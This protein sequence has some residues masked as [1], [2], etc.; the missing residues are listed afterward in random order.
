MTN[1]TQRSFAGGEFAPAL[2]ARAD[3]ARFAIGLRTC[4][5]M[6]V[7]RAGGATKRPGTKFVDV[8]GSTDTWIL[9]DFTA[10]GTYDFVVTAAP[11]GAKVRVLLV[12]GGGA[13]AS[14][15]GT[16]VAGG[17]GG[18]GGVIEKKDADEIPVAVGSYPL[19]LGS[20]GGVTHADHTIGVGS[21][22]GNPGL[23]TTGF[24]LTAEGGGYGKANDAMPPGDG[25]CGGGMRSSAEDISFPL[26]TPVP[27]NGGNGTQGGDG[28]TGVADPTIGGT[29]NYGGGGGGAGELGG[30]YTTGDGGD[31]IASDITGTNAYYGGG[32]GA[33]RM[34]GANTGG[35]GG[36][37]GGGH[38][39]PPEVIGG[40]GRAGEDGKGGG[41]GGGGGTVFN[42]GSRG[43][44]G[45]IL[46]RYRAS[47][48]IVATGGLMTSFAA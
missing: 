5:N 8:V 22:S 32:G 43:G 42:D 33:G 11:A 20:G 44:D 23:E 27:S 4:R 48:G 39:G 21:A 26:G 7:M 3:L 31:G 28:G 18:G 25:G 35:N 38:G 46:I 1:I 30:D 40:V 13:G 47:S 16:N 19:S 14:V 29:L 6:V 36:V 12:A 10:P 15:D 34:N 17:G 37:G 45:R 2:Y 41:G 24:A 9:H